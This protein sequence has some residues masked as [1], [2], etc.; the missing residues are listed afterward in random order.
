M[1]F[2]A[3]VLLVSI[4]PFKPQ[5]AEDRLGSCGTKWMGAEFFTSYG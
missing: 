2:V 1:I 3:V 5:V 4:V